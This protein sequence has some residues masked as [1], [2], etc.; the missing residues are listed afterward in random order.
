MREFKQNCIYTCEANQHYYNRYLGDNLYHSHNWTFVA[1]K[2]K[3]KSWIMVDTYF[4]TDYIA[5]NEFNENDFEFVMD[6]K[7]VKQ[8]SAA[9]YELYNMDDQIGKIPVN[10]GG[11][12]KAPYFVKVAAKPSAIKQITAKQEDIRK[13]KRRIHILRQEIK[14][15][16]ESN[17]E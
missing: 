3:D 5:V 13:L 15:L 12:L 1:V 10:S 17:G 2:T 9:E 14:Q 4:H 11:I 7:K 8:V 16:E 6:P